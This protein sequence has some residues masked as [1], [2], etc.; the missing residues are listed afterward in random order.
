MSPALSN[1]YSLLPTPYSLLP[2]TSDLT[3]L[4]TAIE[5]KTKAFTL[6]I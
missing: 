5:L 6:L 2:R 1:P 4:R 3:Q